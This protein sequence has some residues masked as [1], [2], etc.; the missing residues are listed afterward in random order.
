MTKTTYALVTGASGG[1]GKELASIAAK[2]GY[3]LVLVARE[4]SK[5]NGLAKDLAKQ[6]DVFTHVIACDLS[7]SKSPQHVF[8]SLKRKKIVIDILINNAGFGDYG[9]FSASDTKI[10]LAMIDLNVRA[11][12]ELTHLFLPAMLERKTG[13]IMNLGSVASFLPGPLMSTYFATKAFVLSFSEALSE[14]LRGSGVS[15][16]C[17][18]PG[19]TKTNFGEAA[20]VNKTHSTRTS[21]V[22]PGVVAAFGWSAMLHE[23]PVAIY[24]SYNRASVRFIKFLP[25]TTVARIVRRIQK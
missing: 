7:D 19:S 22:T 14:E 5:L 6:H 11:L 18:C 15:V 13:Y 8:D 10:Q 9:E 17:L 12:T 25:R 20:H 23:K 2:N 3:N 16:T 24:G 21:T 1:I 4:K